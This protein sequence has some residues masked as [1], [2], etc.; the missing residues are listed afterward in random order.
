MEAWSLSVTAFEQVFTEVNRYTGIFTKYEIS[1]KALRI[2][3]S[4]VGCWDEN[5]GHRK[6]HSSLVNHKN[7][8]KT[9]PQ[10]NTTAMTHVI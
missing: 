1:Q 4:V 8:K 6:S 9:R 7:V 2:T 5:S 3:L 10:L